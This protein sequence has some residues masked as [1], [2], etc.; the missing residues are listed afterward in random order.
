[1]LS[2]VLGSCVTVT[3]RLSSRANHLTRAED[4]SRGLGFT[5]AHDGSSESLRLVLNIL[6]LKT[7]L[8]QIELNAEFCRRND[9]LE[10]WLV[11][12]RSGRD[13]SHVGLSDDTLLV[14]LLLVILSLIELTVKLLLIVIKASLR[15]SH[16][17]ALIVIRHHTVPL[18]RTAST[19]LSV[20]IFITGRGHRS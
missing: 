6:T 19:D 4:E 15:S 9:I 12:S 18:S 3:L 5:D 7:N 1:M 10:S 17:T 2:I 11:I 16:L 20:R 14:E 8:P 13:A